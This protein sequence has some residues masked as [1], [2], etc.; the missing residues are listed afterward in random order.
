MS[1]L[2]VVPSSHPGTCIIRSDP[3]RSHGFWYGS[4][5]HHFEQL[6]I[7]FR[8]SLGSFWG[9]FGLYWDRFRIVL[10]NVL[11]SSVWVRVGIVLGSFWDRVVIVHRFGIA[12]GVVFD[13]VLDCFGIAI[14]DAGMVRVHNR[15]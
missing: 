14:G 10:G 6:V 5:W 13:I 2:D 8:N 7:C 11:A 12:L 1:C 15:F 4:V 9:C 3:S